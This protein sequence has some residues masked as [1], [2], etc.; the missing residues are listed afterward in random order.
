MTR[1]VL[2]SIENRLWFTRK[3]W[4]SAEKRLLDNHYH[5][6]L[7]LVVY[8]AYTTSF[9]VVLLAYELTPNDKKL[10]DTAMVVLAVILFGLSL[11]LNSKSFQDRAVRF[12]HGYLTLH[13][14]E[15]HL[16]ILSEK[17]D[18]SAEDTRQIADRYIA[19]LRDVENHDEIDDISSRVGAGSG[20]SSRQV[21][22]VEQI[23]F[24]WWRAW[25]L[26]ALTTMY[27]AP[28]CAFLWFIIK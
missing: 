26:L 15:N 1:N 18:A 16:K 5:T 3:A 4:I 9:S 8:A 22:F 24:R 7:L 2:S 20:L 19:A 14:L 11:Y 6:Q 23:R 25:R 12:K 10:V 28:A 17:T 13:E 21:S 27:L